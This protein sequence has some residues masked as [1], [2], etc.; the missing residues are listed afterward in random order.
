MVESDKN[1]LQSDLNSKKDVLELRIKT[2][3]KQETQV[4]EKASQLQS[5]ILKK[6]KKED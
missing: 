5:E 1:E 3:E 4:K 6:I 2:M